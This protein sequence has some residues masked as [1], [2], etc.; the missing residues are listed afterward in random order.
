LSRLSLAKG[1]LDID[2]LAEKLPPYV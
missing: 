2:G 1:E